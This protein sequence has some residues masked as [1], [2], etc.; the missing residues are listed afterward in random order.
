MR[1]RLRDARSLERHWQRVMIQALAFLRSRAPCQASNLSVLLNTLTDMPRSSH[2][3]A[4]WTHATGSASHVL[5]RIGSLINLL[6]LSVNTAPAAATS[7]SVPGFTLV[8]VAPS[9]TLLPLHCQ[10]WTLVSGLL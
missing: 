6:K 10:S 7:E 9:T 5:R 8:P 3:L 4:T 2:K 1:W